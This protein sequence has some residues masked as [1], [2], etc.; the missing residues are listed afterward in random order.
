MKKILLATDFSERSDRALRR[1]TLLA[2][3]FGTS[4]SIVHVVDDDQPR[5]IVDSEHD[6]ASTLLR[7]LCSTVRNVDGISCEARVVLA[8][9][10]AGIVGAAG[11]ERPDLLVMGPHRRQALRDTFV[12]TTAERT[13]RSANCPVLMVNA[14]PVGHY[15]HIMLTTDLSEGAARAVK[16]CAALDI[17]RGA[18]IMILHAFDAPAVHLAMSHT[19]S[20][21]EKQAYLDDVRNEALSKL[22]TFLKSVDWRSIRR[23]VRQVRNTPAEEILAAAKDEN[24][25]LV[26]VGTAGRSGI[27]KYFLGSVAEEVLRQADRDIIVVPKIAK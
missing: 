25:D 2:R 16:V 26:A 19:M 24:A 11:E 3:Q 18:R 15:R 17:A 7:E 6:V 21:D 8:D 1:A 9:P 13:I 14:P 20:R 22:S 10:F 5:R 23:A 27:A 4:L 12:G